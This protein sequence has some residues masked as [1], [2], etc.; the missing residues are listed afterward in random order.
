M[1]TQEFSLAELEIVV[2]HWNERDVATAINKMK[3]WARMGS[4][5]NSPIVYQEL[6]MTPNFVSMVP[7]ALEHLWRAIKPDLTKYLT[8]YKSVE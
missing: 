6:Q 2:E 3:I 8:E 1:S 5:S 4:G 7:D